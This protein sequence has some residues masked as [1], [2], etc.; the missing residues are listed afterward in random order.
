MLEKEALDAASSLYETLHV[1][2]GSVDY[3]TP[4]EKLLIDAKNQILQLRDELCAARENASKMGQRNKGGRPSKYGF[5]K[6][7]VGETMLLILKEAASDNEE[8]IARENAYNAMKS[9]ASRKKMK[10]SIDWNR[11]PRGALIT[12]LK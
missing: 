7:G 1:E 6:L 10:F 2:A 3:Q 4:V 12:R 11:D 8:S 5:D 9:Y